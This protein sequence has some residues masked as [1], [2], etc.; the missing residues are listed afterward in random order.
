MY[1][2]CILYVLSPSFSSCTYTNTHALQVYIKT[3]ADPRTQHGEM[4]DLKL[5]LCRTMYIMNE[6]V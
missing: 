4:K 1:K 2:F 3:L 6:Y 5:S